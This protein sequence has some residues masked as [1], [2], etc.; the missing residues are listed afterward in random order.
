MCLKIIV[1]GV[2]IAGLAGCLARN[3]KDLASSSMRNVPWL[4]F[5]LRRLQYKQIQQARR[6]HSFPVQVDGLS[7]T[8]RSTRLSLAKGP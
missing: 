4:T 5:R 3:P 8:R 7:A 1:S 6:I 2:G